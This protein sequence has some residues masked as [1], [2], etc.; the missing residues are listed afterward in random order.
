MSILDQAL[1]DMRMGRAVLLVVS[2]AADIDAVLDEAASLAYESE[3]ITRTNGNA[4]IADAE[5]PGHI[6]VRPYAS[7]D[8]SRGDAWARVYFDHTGIHARL[9]PA[10]STSKFGRRTIHGPE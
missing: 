6:A 4:G 8:K 9:A 7:A 3:R 2:S 1:A 10:L 5:H